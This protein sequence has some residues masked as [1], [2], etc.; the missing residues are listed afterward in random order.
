MTTRHGHATCTG[1]TLADV[2]VAHARGFWQAQ[3]DYAEGH[4]DANLMWS[5]AVYEWARNL[6]EQ[7]VA[8][9]IAEMEQAGAAEWK[10]V[11][12]GATPPPADWKPDT[13]ELAAAADRARAIAEGEPVPAAKQSSPAA[14]HPPCCGYSY[15]DIEAERS[16]GYRD[17]ERHYAVGL[18][19]ANLPAADDVSE[20]TNHRAHERARADEWKGVD[21][22][23]QLPSANWDGADEDDQSDV[24]EPPA[25]TD[26][27]EEQEDDGDDEDPDG[28]TD[29]AAPA[30]LEE[31]DTD[32][33]ADAKKTADEGTEADARWAQQQE[34]A[35]RGEDVHW[36]DW[37]DGDGD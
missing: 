33:M 22:G 21:N 5:P 36:D 37:A 2:E 10:G 3:I 20:S 34:A 17:G 31:G 12:N 32:D 11:D 30:Q 4:I 1:Y 13:S 14:E 7:V 26:G 15:K 24:D 25:T 16:D 6:Y 27:D 18:V 23:A 8:G 29:Q 9:R 19:E 35:N 28:Q